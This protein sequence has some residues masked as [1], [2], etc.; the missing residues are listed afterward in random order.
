MNTSGRIFDLYDDT[1]G[2]VFKQIFPNPGVVPEV[3]KVAQHLDGATLQQLPDDVFALVMFDE[4]HSLRK[5]ACI[6]SGNTLLSIEYFLKVADSL[7]ENAQQVAAENLLKAA[8]WYKLEL[9]EEKTAGLGSLA[10]KAWSLYGKVNSV[11]DTASR[12][13]QNLNTVKAYGPGAVVSPEMLKGAEATGT[14]AM[15]HQPKNLSETKKTVIKTSGENGALEM[16]DPPSKEQPESLPQPR[17]LKPH[18]DVTGVSPPVKTQEKKAS[19]VA[20]AGKYP[21]DSYEQVKAAS[22]YF[23]TFRKHFSVE[24]RREFAV[25][26]VKRAGELNLPLS[27]TAQV[28]GSSAFADDDTVRAGVDNRL[29]VLCK[30]SEAPLREMLEELFQAHTQLTPEMYCG[31][32]AEFDKVAGLDCHYDSYIVDP[33]ASTFGVKQAS[34]SWSA[35]K[36]SLRADD[37]QRLAETGFSKVAQIFDPEVASAFMEDPVGVFDSMPLPQQKILAGLCRG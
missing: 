3:V 9:G 10:G 21:L 13:S 17:V 14:F 36:T 35:G 34:W 15:P 1:K 37:L 24:E 26:L 12:V 19:R 18:V 4:G 32:L 33:V 27:K 31:A 5:F 28:Y 8:S 6:D 7:P 22:E 25:N 11:K 29:S 30:E 23:D 2:D 16:G 20:L